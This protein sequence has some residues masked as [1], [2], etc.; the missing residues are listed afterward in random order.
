MSA[1]LRNASP[2]YAGVLWLSVWSD[3]GYC[4][5]VR[6]RGLRFACVKSYAW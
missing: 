5:I 1:A 6:K 4:E 2:R 3:G